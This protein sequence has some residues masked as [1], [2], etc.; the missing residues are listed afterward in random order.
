MQKLDEVHDEH[1]L[2]FLFSGVFVKAICFILFLI[3]A[4]IYYIIS[5][6]VFI[7]SV[8]SFICIR[9][10]N[11]CVRLFIDILKG[12]PFIYEGIISDPGLWNA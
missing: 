12:W 9:L 8:Y 1:T 4:F 2:R 5:S 11:L 3:H 6:A 10:L 7:S